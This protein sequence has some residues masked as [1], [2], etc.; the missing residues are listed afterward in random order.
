MKMRHNPLATKNFFRQTVSCLSRK[1][2]GRP[3]NSE[4]QQNKPLYNPLTINKCRKWDNVCRKWDTF[5]IAVTDICSRK[6][7]IVNLVWITWFYMISGFRFAGLRLKKAAGNDDNTHRHCE[8]ERRSNPEKTTKTIYD[9]Q[10]HKNGLTL[11]VST[12][13]FTI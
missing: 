1:R 5:F 10:Y 2:D 7:G 11:T 4:N 9:Q 6:I 8:E 12:K 13:S 3:K